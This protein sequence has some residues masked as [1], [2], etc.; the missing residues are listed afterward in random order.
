M[1]RGQLKTQPD[2][3]LSFI[4]YHHLEHLRILW[5]TTIAPHRLTE[6]LHP[7][8]HSLLQTL[9]LRAYRLLVVRS[10]QVRLLIQPPSDRMDRPSTILSSEFFILLHV[11]RIGSHFTPVEPC[12]Q[13]NRT[14]DQDVAVFTHTANSYQTPNGVVS[15]I[16]WVPA[17][18]TQIL[19]TNAVPANPVSSDSDDRSAAFHRLIDNTFF[20][21][22]F[23]QSWQRP[24]DRDREREWSV[25]TLRPPV[26]VLTRR[27]SIGNARKISTAGAMRRMPPVARRIVANVNGLKSE[28]FL[29]PANVTS[30]PNTNRTHTSRP[31]TDLGPQGCR[32]IL[33]LLTF[34]GP[35]HHTRQ[36]GSSQD[37]GPFPLTRAEGL[38]PASDRFLLTMEAASSQVIDQ[39]LL[40][41]E[42][43]NSQVIDQSPRTTEGVNFPLRGPFPHTSPADHCLVND[44][45]RLTTAVEPCRTLNPYPLTWG[46]VTSRG[47]LLPHTT[48][49]PTTAP[50]TVK[51][52]GKWVTWELVARL[53]NTT[54]A[55][56]V[57]DTSLHL[58]ATTPLIRLAVTP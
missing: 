11:P 34:Q 16:Q 53:L 3:D 7:T 48:P 41:T 27:G 40:T 44:P 58:V 20:S 43:A 22:D 56:R 1:S 35:S 14:I 12:L 33:P 37:K 23:Q 49:T 42:A 52:R 2:I 13:G 39:F 25:I 32:H 19:P 17:E 10:P 54:L 36:G 18:A 45:F 50:P 4:R 55:R 38:F 29:K 30:K 15:G 26:A 6:L 21:Q 31:S 28:S 51:L 8:A 46:A 47:P 57:L 24:S 9:L 5:I